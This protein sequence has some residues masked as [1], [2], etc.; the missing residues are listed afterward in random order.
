MKEEKLF[1]SKE[2]S[3]EDNFII[4][5][6]IRHNRMALNHVR[7]PDR[8]KD[9]LSMFLFWFSLTDK[10][11]EVFKKLDNRKRAG[12]LFKHILRVASKIKVPSPLIKTLI[13]KRTAYEYY[14]IDGSYDDKLVDSIKNGHYEEM[15][16]LYS[17]YYD[18]ERAKDE[19][20]EYT[21]LIIQTIQWMARKKNQRQQK[22]E[23]I[24]DI[25]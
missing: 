13:E 6:A 14:K 8:L 7:L 20:F 22:I 11:T 4:Y 23:K 16:K 21:E 2:N 10:Q 19:F 17:K 24:F 18:Y 25:S 3:K 5:E 9:L 15:K 1:L 12:Y